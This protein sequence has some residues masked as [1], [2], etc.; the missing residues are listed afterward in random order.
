[1]SKDTQSCVYGKQH[2]TPFHVVTYATCPGRFGF[3]HSDVEKLPNILWRLFSW[4]GPRAGRQPSCHAWTDGSY[5]EAAD[6]GWIITQDDKGEDSPIAQGARNLGGQQTAFDAE[7]AAIER[8][9]CWFQS[10]NLRHMTIH[11]DSTSAIARAGHTGAGP[12][13]CMAR[14]IRNGVCSLKSQG[15]MV[16]PVWVKGHEGLP[17]N[18]KADVLAGRAAEKAGYSKT[19]SIAHLKLRI[20]EKFRKAKE[21]WHKAPNHH[22]TEEIPPPPPKKSCLD[23][24]RNAPA[25]TAA[26]IRTGHWRDP[27]FTS[28]ESARW[29]RT[30]AGSVK[31]RLV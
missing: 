24:M 22:G 28:N 6:L 15:K 4:S 19:M 3:V 18:E 27:Q 21:T 5:R 16:D 17:G 31:V 23:S 10:A 13:Q 14:N 25:R 8:V 12:G 1:M 2:R 26:Q 30:N 11:S 20:S 7:V 29:R 9:I